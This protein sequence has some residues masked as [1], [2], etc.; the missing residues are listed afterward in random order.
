[1]AGEDY[2]KRLQPKHYDLIAKLIEN[3][4][5]TKAEMAKAVGCSDRTITRT[6]NSDVFKEELYKRTREEFKD[7]QVK[8]VKQMEKL[9]EEGDFR[10]IKYVLDGCNYAGTIDINAKVKEEVI[11]NIVGEDGEEDED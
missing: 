10:A 7:Y 4:Y 9:A 1:M 11:I 6:V 8:A 3:P 2:I 5:M